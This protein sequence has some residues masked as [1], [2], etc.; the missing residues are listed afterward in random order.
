TQTCEM[1]A[2]AEEN[3]QVR[4]EEFV[5]GADEEI[6]IE[7]GDVDQAVRTVVDG[8]DIGE[9]AGGVREADD[10]FYRIDGA[11]GVGGVADG[12]QFRFLVE[13][14]GE[15]LDIESAIFPVNL[16]PADG[17]AFFFEG[18]PGGDVGVVVEAGDQDFV[19]G[20]EIAAD[21]AGHHVGKAGHVGPKTISSAAQWRKW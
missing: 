17:D 20:A 6:T 5:G 7:R 18:E 15:I 16:G 9:D 4:A 8:I 1:L 21:G 3:A 13:L 10:F 2:L 11:D 14:G 19:A 12:Y